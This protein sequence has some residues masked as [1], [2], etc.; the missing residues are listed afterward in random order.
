M[1]TGITEPLEFAFLF[2]APALYYFIYVPLFGLAYLLTH[3]LNVGVGLTFSGGFIDMFLFGILQG[4]SKTNWIAI[5]IL[6]IFYF[7]G[8]YFIFK[9]V[10][11]KFNLKTIGREDEEMEKD[12]SSEKQIYQKLL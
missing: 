9:F 1:L 4:N 11:M 7:I 12:I 6:G 2:A 5:P 3:L 8:F 10:I